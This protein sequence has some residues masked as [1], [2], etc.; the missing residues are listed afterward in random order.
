MLL[1]K[2]PSVDAIFC[3]NDQ[4]ARGAADTIRESGRTV[5]DD[6]AVVGFDNWD[7]FVAS[8]RPPLTTIDMNLRELGRLT[9]QFLL[10]AIDGRS[11]DGLQKLPCTLISRE[12]CPS[13]A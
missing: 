2:D 7:V 13:E 10:D 11:A 12:S 1:R 3:G 8:C 4:V 5:P 6:V 9:G